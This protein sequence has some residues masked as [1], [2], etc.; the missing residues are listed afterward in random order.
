MKKIIE[1]FRNFFAGK[2]EITYK[3][4][5]LKHRLRVIYRSVLVITL[6]VVVYA[7]VRIHLDSR[8]FSDYEVLSS[9]PREGAEGSV[10]EN[11]CG[12]LLVYSKDGMTAFDKKGTKLWNQPYEMQNPIVKIS[13]EYVAV[14]DYRGSIIYIMNLDGL[15]G[16]VNTDMIIQDFELSEKGVVTAVLDN[17]DTTL[18]RLLSPEG[19]TIADLRTSMEDNGYPMAVSLSQDNLKLGVSY[20]KAKNAKVNT[21]VAFYNFGDVGQNESEHLVSG[22]NVEEE[23][24]PFLEFVNSTT[25]IAASDSKI[26]IF[27]GK[28]IPELFCE[29]PI[30]EEIQ[31]IYHNENYIA[32][33]FHNT[34]SDEKYRVEVYN[35]NGKAECSFITDVEYKEILVNNNDLLVYNESEAE[36]YNIKG[37]LKYRGSLGENISVMIPAES[38]GKFLVVKED[39]IEHIRLR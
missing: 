21:S 29:I 8:T 5:I 6:L 38:R 22:Y 16:E 23:I 33:V 32:L 26:L 28:Q 9:I 36:L 4:K 3:E 24:I 31:S 35:L 30:E 11:Y 25:A 15:A 13:G 27:K 37:D 7:A 34:S 19:V 17:S 1:A 10:Y 18:I 12:N 39:V 14:G 20:L 2:S